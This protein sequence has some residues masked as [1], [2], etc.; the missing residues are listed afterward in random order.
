MTLRF[1]E[2]ADTT[3]SPEAEQHRRFIAELRTRPGYHAALKPLL[4]RRP[5]EVEDG[6]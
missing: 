6:P 3:R 1:R 2:I 5:S 4:D